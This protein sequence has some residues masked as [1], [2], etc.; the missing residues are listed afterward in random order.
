MLKAKDMQLISP[1]SFVDTSV[2]SES[3]VRLD[4]WYNLPES[5]ISF[6][7]QSKNG[8]ILWGTSDFEGAPYTLFLDFGDYKYLVKLYKTWLATNPMPRECVKIGETYPLFGWEPNL[9]ELLSYGQL[10]RRKL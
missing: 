1:S 5:R 7:I 8:K 4:H 2:K 10:I 6:Q 3:P 9:T